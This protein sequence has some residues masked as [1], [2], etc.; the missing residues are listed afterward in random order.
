MEPSLFQAGKLALVDLTGL[1]RDSLHLHIGLLVWLLTMLL[2]RRSP[3]SL[4]PLAMAALAATAGELLDRHNA[5]SL[6][7]HW[8]W[9]AS[10][11]DWVNTLLWPTL[12]CLLARSGRLDTA[13]RA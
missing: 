7:G 5:L 12:L 13:L 11:H 1:S 6:L 2:G 4:L 8:H 3:R 10:L 9:Q